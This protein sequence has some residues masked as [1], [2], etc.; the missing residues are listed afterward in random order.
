MYGHP[1]VKGK[2]KKRKMSVHEIV[3]AMVNIQWHTV[4]SVIGER[5]DYAH[6][7]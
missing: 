4:F 1:V 6:F 7:G 5:I 3:L 2:P